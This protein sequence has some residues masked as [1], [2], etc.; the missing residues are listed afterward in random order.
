MGLKNASEYHLALQ[1][2]N[3]ALGLATDSASRGDILL[4]SGEILE[5][6]DLAKETGKTCSRCKAIT[7]L[8]RVPN[9]IDDGV[10][11]KTHGKLA[12]LYEDRVARGHPACSSDSIQTRSCSSLLTYFSYPPDSQPEAQT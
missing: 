6:M 1:Y 5:A 11:A 9:E 2:L 3:T 10:L 4:L 8:S 7:V 12:A